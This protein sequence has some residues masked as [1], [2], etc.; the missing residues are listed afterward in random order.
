MVTGLCSWAVRTQACSHRISVG[1]TRA[2]VPPMM[3]SSRIVTAAPLTLS[4]A[5][6]RMKLGMSIPVGHASMQGAS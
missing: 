2:Q 4:V 1:H 6:F 3:L 5:I